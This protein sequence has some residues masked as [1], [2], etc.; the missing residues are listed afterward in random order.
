[1]ALTREAG[2][3]EKLAALLS[4]AGISTVEV[5]LETRPDSVKINPWHI[6][7]AP[8]FTTYLTGFV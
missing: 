1:M 5:R 6:K 2:K 4:E 7:N 8:Q 3:N